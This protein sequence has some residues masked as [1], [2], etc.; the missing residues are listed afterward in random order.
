MPAIDPAD[1]RA[2]ASPI[3]AAVMVTLRG[4]GAAAG[5]ARG[6]ARVL[7]PGADMSVVRPGEVLVVETLVPGWTPLFATAAAVVAARGGILCSGAIVA[8]EHAI[9]AVVGT[10]TATWLIENGQLLEV[11]GATGVVQAVASGSSA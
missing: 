10:G 3:L 9:P 8:R 6:P 2:I 4:Q 5:T 11:N 7:H 1:Q